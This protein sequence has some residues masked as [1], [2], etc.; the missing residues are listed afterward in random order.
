MLQRWRSYC[1]DAGGATVRLHRQQQIGDRRGHKTHRPRVVSPSNSRP[2]IVAMNPSCSLPLDVRPFKEGCAADAARSI[3]MGTRQ[4]Y[5][6]VL[7]CRVRSCMESR[8]PATCERGPPYRLLRWIAPRK[9]GTRAGWILDRLHQ[10]SDCH[11][12]RGHP[13][14][15]FARANRAHRRGS[16]IL[17]PRVM[18]ATWTFPSRK[19]PR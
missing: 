15:T 7:P 13:R 18:T 16:L 1:D 4:R 9:V 3:C 14:L 6:L 8:S 10:A 19:L 12:D 5:E 2:V 17:V 11:Q